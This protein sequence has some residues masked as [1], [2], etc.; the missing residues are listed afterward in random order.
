ML[1][2]FHGYLLTTEE[3]NTS[4]DFSKLRCSFVD[5]DFDIWIPG[6]RN[7]IDAE[8]FVNGDSYALPAVIRP[9]IPAPLQKYWVHAIPR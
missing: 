5:L 4:P 7:C 1:L 2:V 8:Y 9:P 3:T 6:Q